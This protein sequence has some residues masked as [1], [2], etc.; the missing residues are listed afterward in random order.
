MWTMALGF[1]ILPACTA[2]GQKKAGKE[3]PVASFGAP[4]PA[5]DDAQVAALITTIYDGI[6]AGH[7]EESGLTPELSARLNSGDTAETRAQFTK[8]G[9]LVSLEMERRERQK[10]ST[11]YE[12]LAT[13]GSGQKH[14]EI[15]MTPDGKV[16]N[17]I[18]TI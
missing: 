12:Y 2:W 7:V 8:L 14:I 9:K 17:F 10:F 1:A 13:F 5:A 18:F 3:A 11:K 6:A 15:Y 16:M 4:D